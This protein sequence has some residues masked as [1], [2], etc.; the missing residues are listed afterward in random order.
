MEKIYESELKCIKSTLAA[1]RMTPEERS[2][3][4]IMYRGIIRGIECY[5][6]SEENTYLAIEGMHAVI[7]FLKEQHKISMTTASGL[8]NATNQIYAKWDSSLSKRSKEGDPL[9]Q[10]RT[11]KPKPTKIINNDPTTIVFWTDGTKTIVRRGSEEQNSRY[12]A[13][14]AALAKKIYGNNT[15]V[16]YIVSK[17]ECV[18]KNKKAEEQADGHPDGDAGDR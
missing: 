16:N 6:A 8:R 7:T 12:A 5:T 13:F 1:T 9:R 10:Y 4:M 14:C 2:A 11:R 15:R 18:R 17:T 3:V